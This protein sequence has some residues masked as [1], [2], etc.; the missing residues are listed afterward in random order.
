MVVGRVGSRE[1]WGR[2]AGDEQPER[3]G[4]WPVADETLRRLRA[5]IF[6]FLFFIMENSKWMQKS[7]T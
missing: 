1:V 7:Q 4:G 3:S 5:P 2:K 6:V